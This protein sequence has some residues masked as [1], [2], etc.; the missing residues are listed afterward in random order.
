MSFCVVLIV[1]FLQ[2]TFHSQQAIAYGTNL[3]GGVSPNKAGTE[4]LGL[5]VFKSV[6][7]VCIS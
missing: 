7:E 2:G 1:W 4:H 6:K 5:P 3:V